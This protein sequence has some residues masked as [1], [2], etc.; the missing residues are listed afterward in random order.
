MTWILILLHSLL[1]YKSI[2]S[3]PVEFS[4]YPY[5]SSQGF[6]P[7]LELVNSNTPVLTQGPLRIPQLI[8][9]N[10]D[11]L[12]I[13]FVIVV[14]LTDI[15]LYLTLL[16]NKKPVPRFFLLVWV[17]LSLWFGIDKPTF[18]HFTLLCISI[19]AYLIYT[20]RVIS[21]LVL[22]LLSCMGL[23]LTPSL[24]VALPFLY[25]YL[26][27]IPTRHYWIGFL[28]PLTLLVYYL[29]KLNIINDFVNLVLKMNYEFFLHHTKIP[30]FIE[31][32]IL[33]ITLLFF[34]LLNHAHPQRL[35]IFIIAFFFG[36]SG[37]P[38]FEITSLLPAL[39][40]LLLLSTD[41]PF[42]YKT[43][44]YGA[45]T[46]C[47]LLL[48]FSGFSITKHKVDNPSR[49]SLQNTLLQQKSQFATIIGPDSDLLAFTNKTPPGYFYLPPTENFLTNKVLLGKLLA[50][51]QI[52]P[53]S[54]VYFHTQVNNEAIIGY[55]K[56]T[57]L[58]TGSAG[59]Y[60]IYES[61]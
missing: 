31:A 19:S 50:Y 2:L 10:P 45:F 21:W 47:I 8:A 16:K 20:K 46:S 55:L 35:R 28:L 29:Q 54:P 18:T 51:I 36:L 12:R 27:F 3:I 34:W 5:L 25:L 32:T 9:T 30:T 7:Y 43:L 37:A 42:G 23:L 49:V 1:V 26:K 57:R 15:F 53:S 58:V 17:S 41:S 44:T 40:I 52:S 56:Q 33:S 39:F 6:I 4:L 61:K 60:D 11:S 59:L 13:L 14:A 22:G 24:I 38:F 48:V